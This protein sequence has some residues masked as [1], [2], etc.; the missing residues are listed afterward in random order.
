MPNLP[1]MIEAGV[2][3][4]DATSWFGLVAPAKTPTGVLK[5][6]DAS[7]AKVLKDPDLATDLTS[8]ALS[9]EP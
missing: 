3:G 5:V 1:T 6:L 2:P 4:F 8:L 9:P 7:A